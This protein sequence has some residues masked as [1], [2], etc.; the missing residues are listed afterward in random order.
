ML[1]N[2]SFHIFQAEIV[3]LSQNYLIS[4]NCDFGLFIRNSSHNNKTFCKIQKKIYTYEI[5]VL[6]DSPDNSAKNKC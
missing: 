3:R 1:F 4:E 5:N 6:M 2:E